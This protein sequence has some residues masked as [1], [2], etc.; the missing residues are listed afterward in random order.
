MCRISKYLTITG[1]EIYKV[2][3]GAKCRTDQV[4][5][6]KARNRP[7]GMRKLDDKPAN[8]RREFCNNFYELQNQ[9]S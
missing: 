4:R 7:L 2:G 3:L 1:S 8:Q 5:M 9:K 6:L